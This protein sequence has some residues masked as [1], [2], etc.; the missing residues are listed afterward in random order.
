MEGLPLGEDVTDGGHQPPGNR[1]KGLVAVQDLLKTIE[2]GCPV[3]ITVSCLSSC[4][5]DHGPAQ[6]SPAFLALRTFG[7][8][9]QFGA[10]GF[11]AVVNPGRKARITGQFFG[12]RKA[13]DIA[14]G[15]EHRYGEDQAHCGSCI[16]KNMSE[17]L[18]N[19][20]LQRQDID[21]RID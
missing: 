21:V 14:N 15:R 18:G 19:E 2:L 9:D 8:C 4:L 6:L 5:L 3:G 7:N 13:V 11:S 12:M 1:Y 16:R 20:A 17:T 10:V